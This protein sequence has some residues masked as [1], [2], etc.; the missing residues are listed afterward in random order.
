MA[1]TKFDEVHAGGDVSEYK[2]NILQLLNVTKVLKMVLSKRLHI[3]SLTCPRD[4]K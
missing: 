2:L 4:A 1:V 3:T